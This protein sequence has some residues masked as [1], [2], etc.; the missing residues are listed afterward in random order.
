M[1]N[2]F[3][4]IKPLLTFKDENHFYFLQVIQRKKDFDKDGGD[5]IRYLGSNNN[6]RLIKAY[7]I[8]S[9][10]QLDRYTSE[11]I[12]LCE[13]FKARAG[14]NLNPRNNRDVALDC[15][16]RLA[17]DIKCNNFDVSKMYNSVCGENK[18]S[19]KH[20]IIDIDKD[21]Y[22]GICENNDLLIK[23]IIYNISKIEPFRSVECIIPSKSGFH[24]IT[25][26][27]NTQKFKEIYPKL[28]IHK[29][30]PTNLY[31]S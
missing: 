9:I 6:N 23:E 20:W 27:F 19:D 3:E 29:N 1:I 4:K 5:R 28:D 14:I 15:L 17:R 7:Y 22:E 24:I 16:E 18:G 30:N 11:I 2:N 21:S 12:G 26:A 13:M 10:E 8:Y 25:K 31:I